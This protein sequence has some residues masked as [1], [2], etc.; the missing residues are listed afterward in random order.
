MKLKSE[1]FEKVENGTKV[2][3]MRLNDE[4][5]Q[6]LQVGDKI[7]FSHMDD[8]SKKLMTEVVDLATFPTFKELYAAY[9]PQDYGGTSNDE[10]EHMYK[11]YPKEEEKKYGVLAI[12][13]KLSK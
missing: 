5:R 11:Y 12:R 13:L 6:L 10:Y 2:I 8:P 7:E 9:P 1:P 3:E 4:K